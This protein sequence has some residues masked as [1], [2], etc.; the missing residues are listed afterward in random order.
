MERRCAH[1]GVSLWP[2]F[3]FLFIFA[4]PIRQLLQL[5][6]CSSSCLPLRTKEKGG[7]GPVACPD[8]E[9]R[10]EDAN[11]IIDRRPHCRHRPALRKALPSS[12]TLS[13]LFPLGISGV[14]GFVFMMM[15]NS[16]LYMTATSPLFRVAHAAV[17]CLNVGSDV[18]RK[19]SLVPERHPS[20][21]LS[22]SPWGRDHHRVPPSVASSFGTRDSA[23]SWTPSS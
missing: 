23:P 6:I 7:L 9:P 3:L 1:L 13:L 8:K 12:G 2:S 21:G 18:P 22:Y 5:S 20:D 10:R 16:I 11:D 14:C 15:V 19:R 17:P 4:F